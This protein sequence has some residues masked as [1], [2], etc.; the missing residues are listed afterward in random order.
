M[1]V[2]TYSSDPSYDGT[3][4]QMGNL[5]EWNDTV[6]YSSKYDYTFRGVLGGDYLNN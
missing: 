5:N 4:D 1:G 3:F 2:G 6:F